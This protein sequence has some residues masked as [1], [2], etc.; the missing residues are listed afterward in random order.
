MRKSISVRIS[1]RTRRGSFALLLLFGGLGGLAGCAWFEDDELSPTASGASAEARGAAERASQSGAPNLGSVPARP[2]PSSVSDRQALQR[3]LQADREAARYTDDTLRGRE[4]A[5]PPPAPASEAAY[6]PPG[7]QAGPPPP[8]TPPAA[9][10]YPQPPASAGFQ[11]QETVEQVYARQIRQSSAT[12]ISQEGGGAGTQAAMPTPPRFEGLPAQRMHVA[13]IV[14]G[15]AS[16][17]LSASDRQIIAAVAAEQ[18]RAGGSVRVI[19]HASSRTRDMLVGRHQ[20]T[21][22]ELSMRRAQ[23]VANAL[24][25]QGVPEANVFFEGRGDSEP[26]FHESMPMAEAYNRRTEIFLER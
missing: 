20:L 22:Y 26:V 7:P 25:R 10:P 19:G 12:S 8:A 3:G 15:N 18:R 2:T 21:N 5:G 4:A 24:V 14:Y 6:P 11:G 16:Y 13:T 9:A 23:A 17:A 1:D